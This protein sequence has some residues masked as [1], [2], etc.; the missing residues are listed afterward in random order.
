MSSWE[1]TYLLERQRECH[2]FS[3]YR[4]ALFP[5]EL[6][7]IFYEFSETQN[8]SMQTHFIYFMNLS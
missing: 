7:N 3:H 2:I 6:Y 4:H 1:V 8:S 5:T